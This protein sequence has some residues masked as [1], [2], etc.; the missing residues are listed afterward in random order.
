MGTLSTMWTV[1]RGFTSLIVLLYH[2]WY[3]SM[4]RA[5]RSVVSSNCV[6]LLYCIVYL[7]PKSRCYSRL[8]NLCTK[9]KCL[10]IY[11]I[12]A[13]LENFRSDVPL[14]F[15]CSYKKVIYMLLIFAIKMCGNKGCWNSC[16]P[17]TTTTAIPTIRIKWN[18]LLEILHNYISTCRTLWHCFACK[19]VTLHY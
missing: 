10:V 2:E 15:Y 14:F 8:F 3:Y 16:C 12:Y 9:I 5:I 1:Y 19:D 6:P 18:F 17:P 7:Q 13:E 11:Y 4:S